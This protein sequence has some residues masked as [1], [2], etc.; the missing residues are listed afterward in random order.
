MRTVFD[1]TNWQA[2]SY[3]GDMSAYFSGEPLRIGCGPQLLAHSALIEDR[4]GVVR[5]VT[6]PTR[7]P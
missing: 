2:T 3:A 6:P 7:H 1:T 4:R 5:K